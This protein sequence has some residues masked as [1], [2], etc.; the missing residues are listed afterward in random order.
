MSKGGDGSQVKIKWKRSKYEHT[1]ETLLDM[2]EVFGDI[3]ECVIPENKNNV[4]LMTFSSAQS[5]QAAIEKYST[6][7]DMRV[8]AVKSSTAAVESSSCAE[9][10]VEATGAS[11]KPLVPVRSSKRIEPPNQM[12]KCEQMLKDIMAF[13]MELLTSTYGVIDSSWFSQ[14][15]DPVEL[16]IPDYFEVIHT[17]MDLGTVQDN[18]TKGND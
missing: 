6:D 12:I 17:P 5:S 14:P 2:F 16:G 4:A 8:Y 7:E 1:S 11:K 18:L 3:E 9:L 13:E 10:V 15:V